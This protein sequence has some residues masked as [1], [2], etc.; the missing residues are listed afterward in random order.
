MVDNPSSKPVIINTMKVLL[1]VETITQK[2][3]VV[4]T[5]ECAM[6]RIPHEVMFAIGG[7]SG[8]N[9]TNAIESYDSRADRWINVSSIS[10]IRL[11]K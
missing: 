3:G 8:G 7:W 11:G 6:P 4:R 1:D 10:T 2:D 5:P 9:S